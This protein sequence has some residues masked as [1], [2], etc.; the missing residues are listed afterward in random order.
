MYILRQNAFATSCGCHTA[1]FL[2]SARLTVQSHKSSAGP[3]L[4]FT[5]CLPVASQKLHRL[6]IKYDLTPKKEGH[7]EV[8]H[9]SNENATHVHK[10][11]EKLRGC[12]FCCILAHVLHPL[13]KLIGDDFGR[14]RTYHGPA[15]CDG[16]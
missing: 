7:A 10:T 2:P 1:L 6:I 14:L 12:F 8:G 3:R 16:E 9:A 4:K 11:L 15:P 5:S 13:F